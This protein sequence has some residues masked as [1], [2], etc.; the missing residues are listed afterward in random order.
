MTKHNETALKQILARCRATPN[1]H[2]MIATASYNRST[3]VLFQLWH[4]FQDGEELAIFEGK[5]FFP[6]GSQISVV[7]NTNGVEIDCI[8]MED[9]T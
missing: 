6:N 5:V 9:F 1:Y 7:H 3:D 8:D 4:M 2:A